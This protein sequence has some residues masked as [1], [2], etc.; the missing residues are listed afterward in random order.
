MARPDLP[1][2]AFE[3][4]SHLWRKT[5]FAETWCDDGWMILT[6]GDLLLEC[7]PHRGLDPAANWFS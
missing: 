3:V 6:R 7:F 5:G 1:S 4:T 2:R